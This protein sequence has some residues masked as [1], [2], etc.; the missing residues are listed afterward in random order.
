ML[1]RKSWP[2]RRRRRDRV[3]RW[4]HGTHWATLGS[5]DEQSVSEIQD[6]LRDFASV[7][8][9]KVRGHSGDPNNEA[10]D[11]LAQRAA[12]G[13]TFQEWGSASGRLGARAQL[14]QELEALL[15]RTRQLHDPTL[16]QAE[17]L[18]DEALTVFRQRATGAPRRESAAAA[19]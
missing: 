2:W 9:T 13:V 17:Q 6:C 1:Q 8:F 12:A 7:S 4:L 14:A 3:A 16:A 10:A 18:L 19:S 15:V 11:R 5:H